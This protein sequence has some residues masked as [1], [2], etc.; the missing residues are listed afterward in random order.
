MGVVFELSGPAFDR[1]DAWQGVRLDGT[2]DYFHSP[3]E[4]RTADGRT[5]AAVMYRKSSLGEAVTPSAQY[6]DHIVAG[7]RAH[8]L[9]ADYIG[10]LAARPS[11]PA[12]YDVPRP[13]NSERF[14]MMGGGSCAC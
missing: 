14:L 9:P 10:Q 1:L 5:M 3:A 6:L 7:A 2:G 11:H 8:G 4:L 12:A 13:D